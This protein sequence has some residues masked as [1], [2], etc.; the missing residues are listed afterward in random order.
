MKYTVKVLA[1]LAIIGLSGCASNG[2]LDEVRAL[3][4]QANATAD[5]ALKTARSAENTAQDAK[6]TAD[7]TESKIERMAKDQ[8]PMHK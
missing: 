3:A 5:A 6:A 4:Q 8:A 2:D 1:L 7:A